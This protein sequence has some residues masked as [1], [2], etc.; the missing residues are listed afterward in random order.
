MAE[1]LICCFCRKPIP[2]NS[3]GNSTW[4]CWSEEEEKQNKG[5]TAR[6]CDGCNL[7]IVIPCRMGKLKLR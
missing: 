2:S 7:H 1:K 4:G 5:E 6:C 3:W